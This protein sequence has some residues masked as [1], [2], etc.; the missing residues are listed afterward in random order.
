MSV[1]KEFPLGDHV[2]RINKLSVF[3]QFELARRLSPIMTMLSMQQD[4]DKLEEVFPTAF[5]A[6]CEGL[7]SS[8][9]SYIFNICLSSATMKQ[10]AVFTPIWTDG[11]PM[12]E[13]IDLRL[14]LSIIFKVLVANNLID[15]FAAPLPDSTNQPANGEG[16]NGSDSQA[17]KTG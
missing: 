10:G 7:T 8:D 6:L 2:Y 17:V 12:F 3:N 1:T 13:H 11:L 4:K 5:A 16:S 15:F 9:S 14:S